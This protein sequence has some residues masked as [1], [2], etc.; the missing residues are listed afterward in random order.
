MKEGGGGGGGETAFLPHADVAFTLADQYIPL[1]Q[2]WIGSAKALF[3]SGIRLVGYSSQQQQKSFEFGLALGDVIET[4]L[5]QYAVR[6][7][8]NLAHPNESVRRQTIQLFVS[9]ASVFDL[10][11]A[12]GSI[13]HAHTP[14]TDSKRSAAAAVGLSA[15]AIALIDAVASD[16]GMISAALIG[17]SDPFVVWRCH[18]VW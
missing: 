17:S 2:R 18:V 10:S 8:P 15:K 16:D 6:L 4:V 9:L 5:L 7:L 14:S 11:F 13:D 3:E 12:A 1:I